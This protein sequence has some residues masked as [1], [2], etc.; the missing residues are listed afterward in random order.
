MRLL[1]VLWRWE[2]YLCI[3]RVWSDTPTTFPYIFSKLCFSEWIFLYYFQL[4]P[5]AMLCFVIHMQQSKVFQ[6]SINYLATFLSYFWLLWSLSLH[7]IFLWLHHKCVLFCPFAVLAMEPRD[8]PIWGN[9]VSYSC[10]PSIF[11]LSV[12]KTSTA[13]SCTTQLD[14]ILIL[15]FLKSLTWDVCLRFLY[16]LSEQT[17]L[18]L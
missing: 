13:Y 8:S 1:T 15:N 18:N 4:F 6:F 9:E 16:I 14:I 11:R 5:F 10:S 3:T 17:F 12:G 7:S 2:Q